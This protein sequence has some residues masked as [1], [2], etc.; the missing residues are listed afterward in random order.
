M[1]GMKLPHFSDKCFLYKPLP[2]KQKSLQIQQTKFQFII[3]IN[4]TV[5]RFVK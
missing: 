2:Q 4:S 3:V 1:P 5:K